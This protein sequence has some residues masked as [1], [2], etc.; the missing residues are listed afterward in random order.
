MDAMRTI[1]LVATMLQL[2]L[3]WSLIMSITD[4]HLEFFFIHKFLLQVKAAKNDRSNSHWI[5]NDSVKILVI[6]AGLRSHNT[7]SKTMM[8]RL[9]L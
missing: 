3:Y 5:K 1:E 9:F 4:F 6:F 2:T 7:A 8:K